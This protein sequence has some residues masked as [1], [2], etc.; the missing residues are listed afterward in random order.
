MLGGLDGKL[1]DECRKKNPVVQRSVYLREKKKVPAR[2]LALVA[3]VVTF[4]LSA[5]VNAIVDFL[6]PAVPCYQL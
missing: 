6:T 3:C 5:I 4:S 2:R 1:V